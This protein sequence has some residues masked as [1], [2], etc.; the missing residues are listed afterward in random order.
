[1]NKEEIRKII[2]DEANLA[3]NFEIPSKFDFKVKAYNPVC[4]DKFEMFFE[5]E[6]KTIKD[7]HFSGIGCT[8]SKASTSFLLRELKGSSLGEALSLINIFLEKYEKNEPLSPES[9]LIF[10]DKSKFKG[11]EQCIKLSWEAL[12]EYLEKV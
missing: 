6:D 1:M 5:H 10:Q 11:R 9:T 4:G 12:K 7:V 3:Y 8:V 2:I